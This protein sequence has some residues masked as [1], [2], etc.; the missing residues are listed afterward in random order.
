MQI[1]LIHHHQPSSFERI[2]KGY[3]TY[4]IKDISNK[5]TWLTL[6]FL[7]PSQTNVERDKWIWKNTRDSFFSVT[8]AYLVQSESLT[9]YVTSHL[10]Q[11]KI[12]SFWSSCVPS[13]VFVFSRQYLQDRLPFREYLFRIC[14]FFDLSR[15]L[16]SFY[17]FL[18]ETT[19]RL[20]VA[21]EMVSLVWWYRVFR[22]LEYQ[23]VIR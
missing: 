7:V 13:K 11:S 21:Y 12:L 22:W 5:Y 6:I 15:I 1:F 2:L 8:L 10:V 9:L 17:R 16:G 3:I 14:V 18:V 4:H 19:S 23:V 20:F